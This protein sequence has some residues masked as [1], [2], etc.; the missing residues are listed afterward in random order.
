MKVRT[1]TR[2]EKPV[3]PERTSE[4]R[5]LEEVKEI[6]TVSDAEWQG[7]VARGIEALKVMSQHVHFERRLQGKRDMGVDQL[8]SEQRLSLATDL[9]HVCR[10]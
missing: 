6:P 10:R 1:E 4:G 5:I 9:D 2:K 3:V 8:C 7:R